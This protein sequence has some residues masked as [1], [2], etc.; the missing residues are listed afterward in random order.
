MDNDNNRDEFM[1]LYMMGAFDEPNK[2][3][4]NSGGGC[5]TSFILIVSLPILTIVGM[6]ML[7]A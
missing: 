5:L 2:K 3:S 7:L 4:S 6:A 1:D